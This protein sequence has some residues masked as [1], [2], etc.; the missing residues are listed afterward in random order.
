VLVAFDRVAGNQGANTP[1]IDGVT[2]AWV[3][4]QVGVSRFLDDLPVPRVLLPVSLAPAL[5]A[6]PFSRSTA[7]ARYASRPMTTAVSPR[8]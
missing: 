5:E 1:G 7:Q 6:E 4:E 2:A 8:R 3:E